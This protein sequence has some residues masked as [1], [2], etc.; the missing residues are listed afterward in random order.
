M[1]DI[2]KI[3]RDN[4]KKLKPYSSARDE[5]DG[6]A[7]VSLDANENPFGFGLNRYPDGSL[8]DLKTAMAKYRGVEIPRLIFGNGSDELIDLLIRAFCEPGQDKVMIFPPTF[9]MYKVA[10]DVNDIEV[11]AEPLTDDFQID[12][13]RLLPKLTDDNLKIIFICSPN[14]PTGNCI[15]KETIL[16]IT[17]AFPGLV[18]VD[19]AYIDFGGES[20]V[21]HD[22]SNLFIL[23]TFSKAMG[24]AGARLG[25]GFGSTDVIGV[26]NKIK[27]PYNVNTLT[28]EKAI[29]TLERPELI[30]KQVAT[31]IEER[32]KMQQALKG[33]PSMKK[34]YPSD[35]NFLLVEFEDA[36]KTYTDLMT[37][38][39]I[40]RDRSSQVPDTLRITIGTPSENQR[41]IAALKEEEYE[42][43]GRIGRCI[44][45]TSETKIKVEVNLDDPTNTSI[46]TGVAFFDHMLDQIAR[47]GAIGLYVEV[48][49]D[50]QIDTHHTIED[51]AL[52]LGTA[53]NDALK[54]RK[55]I[56]RY[57]FL[58][59]M[60][61]CL[62]QVAIDFG[63]RPWLEWDASFDAT[64]VGEMPTEMASH[65]FKSFSDT[66]RCNLNVKAEG[67]NDHH[68]I[69][70]IFKAFARAIKMAVRKDDSGVMPSTKGVL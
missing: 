4:V 20:L 48:E 67:E 18:V 1:F 49:G 47:H 38:G 19:E 68:K 41:L 52:A 10:A 7:E 14:N 40:V 36:Q 65:F 59:P 44:R 27:P 60:D 45:T 57:G 70:S 21:Q 42:E 12:F 64:H 61:D 28:Q 43:K 32:V 55:G 2:N 29:N 37:K 54:E 33:I 25:V 26:L 31:L 35:A 63:G 6:V 11:V 8:S 39:I 46:S 9:G 5:F 66:A 56:E 62:A 17:A 3:T 22:I 53:F 58:L 24:L 16:S 30:S 69:E 50:I 23:Q 51:T 15:N 34:V 13:D